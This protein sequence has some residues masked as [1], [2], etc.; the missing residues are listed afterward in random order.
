[1][2][3]TDARGRAVL[4][5][6]DTGVGIA[7]EVVDRIFDPFFTTKPTGVGTGLGLSICR[8]IVLALGGEIVAQGRPGG[9]TTMR[10]VLPAAPA[11][12]AR[13]TADGGAAPAGRRGRVLVVDD[14]PAVAAAIRRVLAAQHDVVVRGSAEEALEAIGR[15]ERFD[16]ILCDLMMPR[17]TGMELH[18]TPARLAPDQAT[19]MVVL[20]GGAFTDSAREFLD[21]VPLPRC[22]KPFDAGGLR[23][24]VRK[25]VG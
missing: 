10:V 23:E 17:M 9:G 11:P 20:T 2:T 21:R 14:E 5:V 16:A 22:E 4:E 6:R 1:V 8:G 24:V 13:A 18:E 15:G 25:V 19:R 7:P 3:G 12:A